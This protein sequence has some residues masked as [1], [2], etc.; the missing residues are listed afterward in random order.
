MRIVK[1]FGVICL[2]CDFCDC[3]DYRDFFN[4]TN[5]LI[6]GIIV[7]T[8]SVVGYAQMPGYRRGR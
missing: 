8:R 6:K 1:K 4:P 5:H 7:Q 2:N 3:C